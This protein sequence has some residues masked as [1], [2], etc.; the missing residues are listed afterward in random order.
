MPDP[1]TPGDGQDVLAR[2]KRALE[3]RDPDL[4]VELFSPAADFKPDPFEPGIT[5]VNGRRA[6][7]NA[8][9]ASR[10][11]QEFDAERVWVSGR[12]VL[13]SWHGAYTDAASS[14]RI[15]ERG[16]ITIELDDAGLVDRL[17]MWPVRRSVGVDS[18]HEPIG[19]PGS[20][21]ATTDG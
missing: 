18:R 11:Q 21:R 1:L 16:F 14:Q 8:M 20:G 13:A 12:T 3:K 4:G 10:G 6:W 2:L 15:R 5:D 7:W 19:D 9:S 17:R